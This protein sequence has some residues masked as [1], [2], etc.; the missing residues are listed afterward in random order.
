MV[1]QQGLFASEPVALFHDAEG[2]IR[3]LPDSIP[4][5]TAQQWFDQARQNIGWMS[6]QRMMY[7]REVAVPRLLA[8]FARESED[9]PAPLGEAFEAVRSLLGAPFNRVGLNLYRDGNDSV[10]LHG[11]KTEKLLPAQP[12]AIVSLGASRRMSIRPKAG[13]G[14]IVHVDL[15]P[16]SCIVMS[17]ASQFTHEHGIPKMAGVTGPRISLAFRC[18]AG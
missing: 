5:I 6:Q 4:A 13:S 3:Y 9:L 12:I 18:F 17:Y 8:T 15:E 2:G 1:H 16:G 7:D 11:D 14:R 10:A